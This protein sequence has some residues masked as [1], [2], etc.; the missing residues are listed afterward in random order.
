MKSFVFL[1]ISVLLTMSFLPL[2]TASPQ[3]LKE[4]A[5]SYLVNSYNSALGLCY[6]C[7][8][9]NVY[10]VTHD[11]VLAGYVLQKWNREIADNITETVK[12]VAQ[13]Y[14]LLTSKAG[15]PLDT[16]VEILLGYNVDMYFNET[17]NVILNSTYYSS[18]LNTSKPTNNV[19]IGWE[20]YTDLLCYAALVEW[21]KGNYPEADY[22]YEN[23]TEMWDGNGFNDTAFRV[24][25]YYDTYKL[26]LFYFLNDI[27]SK[28]PLDFEDKLVSRVWTCQDSNGGFKTEYYANGSFPPF[29][30]TNVE[31]T[32]IVLLS[33]IPASVPEV[34]YQNSYMLIV[35][36]IGCIGA[37]TF[38]VYVATRIFRHSPR[39]STISRFR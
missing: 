31:T 8:G 29:T 3:H 18:V 19:T 1:M 23:V 36:I 21:R 35:F 34:G 6:E 32:S 22:Y 4:L 15:I 38:S 13:E 17:E 24:N 25:G 11:N 16:R 9:S 28:G 27:L 37:S 33:D 10:W 5:Y 12:R 7:P 30:K 39:R 26:G 20:N 14:H 2:A